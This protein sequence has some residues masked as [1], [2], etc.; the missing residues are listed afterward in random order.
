MLRPSVASEAKVKRS[1]SAPKAGM[2]SGNS[3]LVFFSILGAS[4]GRRR[5]VVRFFSSVSRSMPSIR[6][7]GSSVL[8]S[9][10]LIF[11]PSESRTRPCT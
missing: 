1:A 4:L 9:D 5:P 8:P 11:L 10:L 7:T 6:S 2:P 3:F